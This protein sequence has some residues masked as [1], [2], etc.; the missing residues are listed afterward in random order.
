MSVMGTETQ[1]EKPINL[2]I[3]EVWEGGVNPL[4]YR[5]ITGASEDLYRNKLLVEDYEVVTTEE[6]EKACKKN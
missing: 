5:M 6:A 1:I 3:K 2:E 4:Q